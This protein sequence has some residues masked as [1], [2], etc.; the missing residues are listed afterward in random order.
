MTESTIINR[1][2]TTD[3]SKSPPRFR[4]QIYVD[5]FN[6]E[7][8]RGFTSTFVDICYATSYPF[9]FL[10][11]SKRTPID[12]LKF[13]VTKLSDQDKKFSFIQ[14]DETVSLA[15]SSEF[16]KTCH[17]MKITVQNTDV[18][19]SYINSKSGIPNK[20]LA[21]ITRYLLL[22]SSQKKELWCFAY[23]YDIWIYHQTDNRLR[24]DVPYFLYHGKITS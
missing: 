20:K 9:E 17:N 1:S 24:G 21:N 12:T 23:Q 4:L 14:V 19:A 16:T 22:K 5:L 15:R 13:L 7:S 18:D 3:V 6:V 2:A 11:R 8:I 10:S